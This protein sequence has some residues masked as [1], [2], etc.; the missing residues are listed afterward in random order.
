MIMNRPILN[1]FVLI[2]LTMLFEGL[3]LGANSISKTSPEIHHFR[4][5][6]FL[7]PYLNKIIQKVEIENWPKTNILRTAPSVDKSLLS[8]PKLITREGILRGLAVFADETMV[9]GGGR[10]SLDY[11][12]KNPEPLPTELPE[13]RKGWLLEHMPSR[14]RNDPNLVKEYMDRKLND[15]RKSMMYRIEGS[16]E[17]DLCVAPNSQAAC[18][19]LIYYHRGYSIPAES[20]A[21]QFSESKRLKNLGTIA[22]YDNWKGF[23][24]I[25]FVRDNIAG[26]IDARGELA[27]EALPLAQKIDA[28]IQKQPA[29]SYEQ[30]LAR[31]PAITI[32]TTK[33][34]KTMAEEQ[35]TV[36]FDTSAPAGQ[37]I[38]DVK[39]YVDGQ[40]SWIKDK[41][42]IITNKQKGQTVKVKVVA[43]T[44]ELLTNTFETEVIIPE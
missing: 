17:V 7:K 35:W 15:Y 12:V 31:R 9:G 27:I 22:F 38:V 13:K 10:W 25:M 23:S 19:Y 16:M 40:L 2:L 24:K 41:K 18:E 36:S 33:A 21:R 30:L 43:T 4:I 29:L 1:R 6:P 5:E 37:E 39:V 42:V 26:V 20:I 14:V 8:N 11:L 32:A 34:E 3:T 44:S 28:L